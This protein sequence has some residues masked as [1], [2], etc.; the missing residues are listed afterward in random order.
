M[1]GIRAPKFRPAQIIQSA[2]RLSRQYAEKV[3]LRLVLAGG[4]TFESV[5]KHFILPY[6]GIQLIE[7]IDLG[8]TGDGKKILGQYDVE[9]NIAYLDSCMNRDKGDPRRVFTCWHEVGGHGI[10]QG[11]WLRSE[12]RRIDRNPMIVTT[13]TSITP[14]TTAVLERQANLFAAH[15]AA[16]HWLIT[17]AVQ[18]TFQLSRP[19]RF[20]GPGV[21]CFDVGS[22]TRYRDIGSFGELCRVIAHYIHGYFGGLSKE[23][24][25]YRIEESRIA[26]DQTRGL[27][28]PRLTSSVPGRRMKLSRAT[29]A[30]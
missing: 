24:L 14:Q 27:T 7:D 16:P 8:V 18:R 19:F 25:G 26:I 15:A 30:A 28:L 2:K 29:S 12:L 5:H 13:E 4:L 1:N 3:G 10:L 17:H 11:D 21:Y 9:N 6:Y 22:G 23:A 20:I